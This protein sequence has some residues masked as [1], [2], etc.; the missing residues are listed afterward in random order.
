MRGR[1]TPLVSSS[2][3]M[4]QRASVPFSRASPFGGAVGLAWPSVGFFDA[5]QE[6]SFSAGLKNHLPGVPEPGLNP[7]GILGAS[8]AVS[9]SLP[10]TKG[11]QGGVG[12]I[13]VIVMR[14]L[15]RGRMVGTTRRVSPLRVPDSGLHGELCDAG[16]APIVRV[17]LGHGMISWR[18]Q[19]WSPDRYWCLRPELNVVPG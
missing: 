19:I 11:K 15:T 3:P 18:G 12:R 5:L 16:R 9:G 13:R 1:A 14:P 7:A 2:R 10:R 17:A 8:P 6:S 4:L